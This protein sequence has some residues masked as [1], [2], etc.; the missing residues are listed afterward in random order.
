[1]ARAKLS[2]SRIAR[3][4]RNGRYGDGGNLWLQV[5]NS[6]AGKSWLF[7]WTERGTGRE[8][9]IGLGSYDTVDVERARELARGFRRHL[10]DGK[11]PALER[12]IARLDRQIEACLMR[13]ISQVADEYVEQKIARKSSSYKKETVR[14]LKRYVHDT[15]GA[16]PTQKVDRK[17]ILNNCKLGELWIQKHPTGKLL[18]MHLDRI[19]R[20]AKAA[21]YYNGDNPAAW[22][23]LQNILPPSSDVH[24]KKHHSALPYKE[25]SQFVEALR[26]YQLKGERERSSTILSL[27]QSARLNGI[28]VN[29]LLRHIKGGRLSASRTDFGRGKIGYQINVTELAGVYGF[30]VPSSTDLGARRAGTQRGLTTAFL[31]EF[32]VLTGVRLG[33]ARQATWKE[34]DLEKMI[35]NVPP[36][37]R[38]RGYR[39]GKVRPIPITKHMLAVL[40]EM[41]KRRV[42]QSPEAIVFL[43][44][45]RGAAI[46]GP[47]C[48]GFISRTLKWESTITI[49][50][51]RS[52]LKDWWRANGFPMDL[53]EIQVDHV[54]GNQVGQAYGHD[55]LIEER[56]VIMEQWGDFCCGV[57]PKP[58]TGEVVIL[59]ERR[60]V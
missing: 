3:L 30:P 6:G 9:M 36:E 48:P 38:K 17:T 10:L 21:G 25:V 2:A 42:D 41:Q 19:F 37:H 27:N 1:M 58:K 18:Q 14:Y 51:F 53:Y 5:T 47:S 56:R 13:T 16:M 32:V 46:H 57:A 12:K 52:T 54:L 34:V 45:F 15:I 20:F 29:T 44:P 50:G 7:R 49:H 43:S 28:H 55:P 33:E 35:W 8:R 24:R 26:E 11:D 23:G 39:T 31:I 4:T 40:K 60:T 59:S 22:E